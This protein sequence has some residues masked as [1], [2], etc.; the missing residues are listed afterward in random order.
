MTILGRASSATK[1][2]STFPLEV[3]LLPAEEI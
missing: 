1:V 2:K 3:D